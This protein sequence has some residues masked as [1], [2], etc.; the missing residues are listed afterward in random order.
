ML[1][2]DGEVNPHEERAP[3]PA[4]NLN[5]HSTMTLPPWRLVH[6]PWASLN[7]KIRQHMPDVFNRPPSRFDRLFGRAPEKHTHAGSSGIGHHHLFEHNHGGHLRHFDNIHHMSPHNHSYDHEE[8]I[9][10][11]EEIT[12]LRDIVNAMK[13]DVT[14]LMETI[15]DNTKVNL[16]NCYLWSL[17]M[18]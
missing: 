10:D 9:N 3:S 4:I 14:S 13:T 1:E 16:F 15:E 12:S 18:M 7:A 11:R 8:R 17:S 2:L 5:H 6:A